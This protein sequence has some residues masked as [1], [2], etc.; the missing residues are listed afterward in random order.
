VSSSLNAPLRLYAIFE[1]VI[2]VVLLILLMIMVVW[3]T[4]WLAV[5]IVQRAAERIGGGAPVTI[6]YLDGFRERLGLL[7]EVFAGFMLILIGLELMKS[8]TVYLESRELH[9]EVVFTV[10]MTAV[11][12]HTIELDLEKMS[13][14]TL[15]GLAALILALALGYFYFRKSPQPHRAPP[16]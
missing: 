10:A 15:I 11:A 12:R 16:G 4:G 7:R 3:G 6:S 13:G 14:L 1:R 9:V 2:V 5:Q 8:L